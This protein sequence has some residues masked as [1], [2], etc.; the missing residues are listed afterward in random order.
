MKIWG[1][2]IKKSIEI[3]KEQAAEAAR[4]VKRLRRA[5]EKGEA[6]GQYGLGNAYRLG[7]GVE[8]D[9][10]EANKWYRLAAE[11]NLPKAWLRQGHMYRLGNGVE[12]DLA[13]AAKWYRRCAERVVK[14]SWADGRDYAYSQGEDLLEEAFL[15]DQQADD[16]CETGSDEYNDLKAGA[17]RSYRLAAGVALCNLGEHYRLGQGLE[18]DLVEAVR[19]Y[20]LAAELGEDS[21]RLNLGDAYRLGEGVEKDLAEA[22]KWYWSVINND[23]NWTLLWQEGLDD[24]I[25]DG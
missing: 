2:L 15:C 8:K 21:A 22:I 5:A 16:D 1:G 11:Q 23:D 19:F 18:K 10:A 24:D 9:L 3:Q 4:E 17:A 7:E 13:E 12:K 25:K 14:R 6:R 20:R